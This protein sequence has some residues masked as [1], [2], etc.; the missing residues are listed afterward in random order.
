MKAH[1]LAA[2]SLVVLIGCG[3]GSEPSPEPQA[4]TPPPPAPA[5]ASPVR[6]TFSV[7]VA[8]GGAFGYYSTGRPAGL[9]NHYGTDLDVPRATLNKAPGTRHPVVLLGGK[10]ETGLMSSSQRDFRT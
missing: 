7:D 10:A 3:G 8:G 4:P 9:N 1:I 2:L 5:F 6:V